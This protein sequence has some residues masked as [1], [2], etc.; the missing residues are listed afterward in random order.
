MCEWVSERWVYLIIYLFI[1]I[2]SCCSVV[3]CF[4]VFI[5][6]RLMRLYIIRIII[7]IIIIIINDKSNCGIDIDSCDC[8]YV[9]LFLFYYVL[10]FVIFCSF[11]VCFVY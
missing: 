1:D 5:H 7:I 4:Y 9:F 6:R 10:Y 11:V 2:C 3:L 8:W